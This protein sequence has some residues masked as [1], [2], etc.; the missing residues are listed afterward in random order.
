L[1][2]FGGFLNKEILVGEGDLEANLKK[3]ILNIHISDIS[4]EGGIKL[5]FRTI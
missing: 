2:D 3:G 5:E 1:R 4:G